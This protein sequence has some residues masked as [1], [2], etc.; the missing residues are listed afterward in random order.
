MRPL[1]PLTAALLLSLLIHALFVG[2][3]FIP[4]PHFEDATQVVNARLLKKSA[5]V[6]L[7]QSAPAAAK[8]KGATAQIGGIAADPVPV[9]T[10]QTS[11]SPVNT[12]KP[13][14]LVTAKPPVPTPETPAS[15][16]LIA[17]TTPPP[18]EAPV[19]TPSVT[20]PPP[21]Q[22]AHTAPATVAFPAHGSAVYQIAGTSFEARQT[23]KITPEGYRLTMQA[24]IFFTAYKWESSGT[25]TEAGISPEHYVDKRGDK[26]RSE[27]H[28]DRTANTLNYGE[29]GQLITEPL[30]GDTQD[31]LSLSYHLATR[32]DGVSHFNLRI[33]R[34]KK[35]LDVVFEPVAEEEIK[36]PS[37]TLRT[38]HVRAREVIS[39]KTV[40][41]WLDLAHSNFPVRLKTIDNKGREID[42][43]ISKLEFDNKVIYAPPPSVGGTTYQ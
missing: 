7:L 38:A 42:L 5:R 35:L 12:E 1:W 2:S 17:K 8:P 4:F 36:L 25:I 22:P 37:G 34:G 19:S 14:R 10:E 24:N 39:G 9:K 13:A 18:T 31:F 43:R 6:S 40:D 23:W 41:V 27:A 21:K 33:V 15:T 26:I 32:F 20:P 3:D 28:F 11:S 29:P 30:T 16:P